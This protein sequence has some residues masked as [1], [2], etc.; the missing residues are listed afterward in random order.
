MSQPII[1]LGTGGN[2]VDIL[3]TICDLNDSGPECQY[4]CI[5]FLDDDPAKSG[6]SIHDF[7]VLGPLV[8]ARNYPEAKFINGIG[9]HRNYRVKSSIIARTQLPDERFAT[10]V[11]PSACVSRFANL[12]LGTAILQN[13]T[14]ASGVSIGRHVVILAGST[15]NH[16]SVVGDFSCI[17]S[18]VS[19][20]GG[21]RTGHSCYLG[22]NSCLRDGICL[23]ESCMI[24]MGSVVRH[25]VEPRSIMV[26]NPARLLRRVTS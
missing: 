14:V 15:V 3:E 9:S 8:D 10:I 21:V 22:T 1:I 17:A 12:G 20:S 23:G 18:G 16:D 19:I 4:R 11:H 13:V 2:C 26:G 25:D 7:P 6:T 24:G 5:G